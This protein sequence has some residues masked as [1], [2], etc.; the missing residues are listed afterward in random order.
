MKK[1]LYILVL[2]PIWVIGQTQSENY[3]KVTAYK[4]P[5]HDPINTPSDTVATIQVTYY[6]GLG[7]P[8]QKI[9]NKQSNTGKDI[10]T[11]IEYDQFGRQAKEYLPYVSSDG[12][13]KFDSNGQQ[14]TL[15][16]TD[17]ASG[18]M[19]PTTYNGQNPYS[20][21]FYEA[22]PLNRVLK[23][24]A[25][26]APWIGHD[27]DDNDHTIKFVYQTNDTLEVKKFRA[28]VNWNGSVGLYTIALVDD[29][30]YLTNQ[31]YKNIT[32]NENWLATDGVNNTTEEFKDKEGHVVLK[33][34]YNNSNSYN[35]FYVYDKYGN[36][37]YVIPPIVD[38]NH[39]INP[40][41]LNG[42]CYQY[43][44]DS[45]N[46]LV[47]KKLPGKQWEYI[48]Y[49]NLDRVVATGPSFNPFGDDSQGWLIT[50]YDVFSRVAYTAWLQQD[51]FGSDI[52]YN[53]QKD[54]N[55]NNAILFEAKRTSYVDN[56]T[57]IY[58]TYVTPTDGYKTLTINYY[59]DYHFPNV[60][61]PMP[62][63]VLGQAV[64]SNT[65]GMATGT[66]TRVLTDPNETDGDT[67]SDFFDN[68]SR[69]IESYTHNY[70]GGYTYVKTLYNFAG[71]ELS[72]ETRQSKNQTSATTLVRERFEYTLQGRLLNHFHQIGD[73]EPEL[74][75]HN[76]YDELGKLISKNV[77]GSDVTTFSG[78]QKVDYGYNI[79]GWLKNINNTDELVNNTDP[80]DLFAFKINYDDV[81]DDLGG[82]ITP[83]YNGNISETFWRTASDNTPRKYGYQYDHLNRLTNAVYQKPG[84]PQTVTNSYNESLQYDKNGNITGLQRNGALDAQGQTIQI[85][86]L[87]YRYFDNS[88]QLF[89]VTD[90]ES[91]PNGF[92]DDATDG[93]PSN[94]GQDYYYDANGNMIE[95]DNK[96][97]NYIVYNHL[98][99]PV[100][101]DLNNG[102]I[103]YI[104]DATGKKVQ[105]EVDDDT[106]G[107]AIVTDYLDGFQYKNEIL[108][109]FPTAEGYVNCTAPTLTPITL[110]D[111][112][113]VQEMIDD[114]VPTYNYVYNYLD[115]LGNI[116]LSY[117]QDPQT[118]ALRIIEENHYYPFGL[119]HTNY[120][121]DK[122]MYT[123]EMQVLKIKPLPP[124]FK[125]SYD[126]K[127][128]GK[129][130]QDELGLNWY[131]Y[132]SRFYDPARAGWS[133]VDPLAEKMRRWSPYNYC[134]D[135][136]M[137]FTDPDGMGPTTDIFNM[138]GVKIGSD[139]VNNGAKMLV[140]DKNE[141][142]QIEKTKGNVDLNN[143]KS[144]VAV[145]SNEVI[146]KMDSAYASSESTGKENG[147][148]VATDGTTSSMKEG[149]KNKVNLGV[150]YDEVA[151]NG[152]T[153]SY[154]V[155]VHPLG[156]DPNKQ[157]SPIASGTATGDAD[158][159]DTDSYGKSGPNDSPSVVLGY[160]VQKTESGGSDI[161]TNTSVFNN[162]GNEPTT[163]TTTTKT[164]GFYN[165]NGMVGQPV[166]YDDL[167]K[168]AQKINNQ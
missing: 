48:V 160:D 153:S 82:Q 108:Q 158:A 64:L 86:D 36:L 57:N 140:T 38:A 143:V 107:M 157:G 39:T 134:F 99:L 85:D 93:D 77:G 76:E 87:V 97:I 104:Y 159:G 145:P 102:V 144:G 148:V 3:T 149:S 84:M 167:K 7:R 69:I 66:W 154:D 16:Y 4:V 127:Y 34:T 135:N 22:S 31:L 162:T 83:L 111:G 110:A 119:K 15:N 120:N 105:K 126:Y 139:G 40:E 9:A 152:K 1:I 19:L 89:T 163:T 60:I 25:P 51:S 70:L 168:A 123:K 26:G 20:Q 113:V 65:K 5:T 90:A 91:N 30:F 12:S 62:S 2:F 73:R 150:K 44:Y 6:D 45:R 42:L 8:I 41:I 116:R 114:A 136:P 112:S 17:S 46:R 166:K 129:E 94:D 49:D 128:N 118:G 10:I 27:T 100:E 133:T 35:T 124:L 13:L 63:E 132:G 24:A 32:K 52:R 138:K 165:Q 74:I 109:F 78:L 141:A 21:K 115:H 125:T 72:T 33:R 71:Q 98:N 68:K 23:Q 67:I 96:G 106:L 122:N 81:E 117:S 103:Y 130:Y 14:N 121:S 147:F 11:H 75:A 156:N 50:K 95:D 151:A 142:K 88:N 137:I 56:V 92:S 18:G 53:Y 37:T 131:D 28:D 79:R 43:K 58:T 146:S 55:N 161:R 80:V 59:D 54:Y 47:E 164:V 29:G 101:I 61:S 155:H